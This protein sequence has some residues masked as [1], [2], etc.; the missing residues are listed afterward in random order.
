MVGNGSKLC[1]AHTGKILVPSLDHKVLQLK[2]VLHVP[3]IKKNLLSVSQ[4]AFDNNVFTEFHSNCC[5]VKDKET[6]QVLLQGTLKDGLYQLKLADRFRSSKSMFS[7]SNVPIALE[8]NSSHVALE[9]SV[10]DSRKEL[11]HR[12]FGH[13][14]NRIL[15]TILKSCNQSM[16]FNENQ[17]FCEACQYGKS[18]SLPFPTSEYHA[19]EP[20]H[21]IH[22]DLWGP[23]PVQS[24]DGYKYYIHFLDDY[25]R[26]TWIYPLKTKG[27]ALDVFIKFKRLVEN[28]FNKKIKIVQSDWGG[29]YRSFSKV[30]EKCGIEFR[31]SCP[32]T[33][34]QNGRAERKHRHIVETGLTLL[35]Q[36]K[37]PLKYWWYAF[38]TSVHLIN[39]MPTP[40]L[41]L[42]SPIQT[43]YNQKP[44]YQLLKVFG[45][46]CFPC[47]RP[48]HKTKFQFHTIKCVFLGYSPGH[49]GYLCLSPAGRDYVS[50][51]V[52]FNE[53]NFP[54]AHTKFLTNNWHQSEHSVVNSC[55]SYSILPLSPLNST[56]VITDTRPQQAFFEGGSVPSES[57]NLQQPSDESLAQHDYN[58]PSAAN[59]S[60]QEFSPIDLEEHT[61]SSHSIDVSAS[62]RTGKAHAES[63]SM[64]TRGKAGIFKPK[65]Y[66]TNVCHEPAT[67]Q[68]ALEN[69][70]WHKA[71]HEEMA[72]LTKNHT[73][74]LVPW[75]PDM[76]VVENKW[77]FRIKRKADGSIDRFKARLVAKGYLQTPGVDF[78]E[79][80]SP[81]IKA[82]TVRIILTIAISKNWK[83]RQLDVNNA[84]LNGKLHET[85]YMAQPEGFVDANKPGYVCKLEKAIY[86]LRQ[87]PRTWSDELRETLQRWNFIQSQCE[88]FCR[89]GTK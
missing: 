48:Y 17:F 31:H 66:I 82:S 68:E 11:F 89:L 9:S 53:N 41:N 42:K 49:K 7:H 12:R 57:E 36:A 10:V 16:F 75:R 22:T 87:A 50:R 38:Q 70:H 35:A 56:D 28:R 76:N 52:I 61:E 64:V 45:C 4:L 43:L 27:D 3:C 18:H 65:A 37:M 14:S 63:H 60:A 81:V 34:S 73:W 84:F 8:N 69:E 83:I 58:T 21:L 78:T 80:Y 2:N 23:A 88:S 24:C 15:S 1:I 32:H 40:V 85:V 79:T 77:V 72:A 25:S 13:P 20:L 5:F 71:M 74:Q 47:L 62:S 44:N 55:S 59:S 30:L 6:G 54:F 26:H 51:S 86:G 33:S 46:A 19:Q 29:E 67:V 39:C